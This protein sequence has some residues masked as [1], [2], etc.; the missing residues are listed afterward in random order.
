MSSTEISAEKALKNA[1]KNEA[2]RLAKLAKFQAKQTKLAA[3]AEAVRLNVLTH[4][5]W[6]SLE[7]RQKRKETRG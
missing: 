5:L 1:E 7:P 3:A 4:D 6:T 2:K